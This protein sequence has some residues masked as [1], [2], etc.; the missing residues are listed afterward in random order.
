MLSLRVSVLS[1]LSCLSP[2]PFPPVGAET[3]A[4]QARCHHQHE[5]TAQVQEGEAG[6]T[7]ENPTAKL[8]SIAKAELRHWR[9]GSVLKI[10]L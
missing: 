3:G 2:L 4:G 5:G 1:E 7:V 9:N 8:K 6:K 10:G